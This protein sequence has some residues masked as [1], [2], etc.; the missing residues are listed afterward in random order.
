MVS[1]LRSLGWF[2]ILATG[3]PLLRVHNRWIRMLEFP[4]IQWALGCLAVLALAR[5]RSG[6]RPAP[7]KILLAAS[8]LE[9]LRR[10]YPFTLLK[11]PES[12]RAR[13]GT[14]ETC[15]LLISN[16]L[17]TNR[18][19]HR[20]LERV[21][22]TDPDL[23]LLLETDAEWVEALRG[24]DEEYRWQVKI[25]QSNTYG[26]MLLSRHPLEQVRVDRRLHGDVPSIHAL[27]RLPSGQRFRL[28]GVHP[29]P[30]SEENTDMRDA[31][32]YLVG[33]EMEGSPLPTVVA[34]DLNDVAWSRTTRL[35]QKLTGTL[36]PRVGRGFYNSFH[37]GI[38]LLR[39]SLDHLFHTPHFKLASMR[40]L[41]SIGSDHFPLLIRLSLGG[42]ASRPRTP[43][44]PGAGERREISDTVRQ[45]AGKG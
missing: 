24:L 4:R 35:F 1:L 42:E 14:G 17:M 33:R 7:W 44:R 43:E 36:D 25:P 10:L 31:E 5:R 16:V 22:E 2:L 8:L 29:R 13:E 34:G 45:A 21:R 38:P 30:P 32:L 40:R 23:I 11:A 19:F 18:R 41:P 6:A 20:L 9:Q 12:P 37:A 15:S 27:V 28:F 26:M 3:L 39:Y